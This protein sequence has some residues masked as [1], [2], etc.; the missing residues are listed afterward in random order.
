MVVKMVFVPSSEPLPVV[1]TPPKGKS[2]RTE[3]DAG[4]ECEW[5]WIAQVSALSGKADANDDS[6]RCQEEG[7]RKGAI[8]CA[9]ENVT[10]GHGVRCG[11]LLSEPLVRISSDFV[12]LHSCD[13]STCS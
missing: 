9:R 10:V 12:R 13:T 1:P 7:N 5:P 6:C 11:L 2:N 8:N 4:N 3:N